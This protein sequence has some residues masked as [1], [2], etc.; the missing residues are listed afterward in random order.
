MGKVFTVDFDDTLAATF[1]TGWGQGQPLPIE[2]IIRFV[3]EKINEGFEAHIVTF[4]ADGSLDEIN[5]FCFRHQIPIKGVVFTS[6]RAKVDFVKELGSTLH[7]DDDV[8]TCVLI[9][10]AG[11][12]VL[13]VDWGQ[14]NFN[15]TANLF[16]RI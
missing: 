7:I 9:A 1:D 11:I 15:S 14:E 3:K 5:N 2:R 10:S 6:G 13:L 12:P 4:R 8:E 16:Q